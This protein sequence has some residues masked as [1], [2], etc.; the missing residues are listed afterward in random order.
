MPGFVLTWNCGR[1]LH[2]KMHILRDLRP[3]VAVVAECA[4]PTHADVAE[5]VREAVTV[6][7]LGENKTEGLGVLTFNGFKANTG[8]STQKDPRY[9]P[10]TP[11]HSTVG[12][13]DPLFVESSPLWAEDSWMRR[14]KPPYPPQFRAT[15]VELHRAGRTLASLVKEFGVTDMTIRSW[16]KQADLDTG[17]RTDGLTSTE[18][19]GAL[20]AAQG[21]RPA[22]RGAGHPKKSRGLVRPGG[23]G[24]PDA[25]EAFRFVRASQAVHSIAATCR[26]LGVSISGYHAWRRRGTVATLD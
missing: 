11:D 23:R 24:R 7:W 12:G 3:D 19:A 26:A 6:R 4:S 2:D 22:S 14:Y 25:H 20:A 9:F 8:G 18:E 10:S 5:V 16:V 15:I 17:R 21:E 13:V 1:G